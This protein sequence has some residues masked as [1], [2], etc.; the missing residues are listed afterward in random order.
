ML[1]EGSGVKLESRELSGRKAGRVESGLTFTYPQLPRARVY[2]GQH[3]RCR[4]LQSNHWRRCHHA[5]HLPI[6]VSTRRVPPDLQLQQRD[7]RCCAAAVLS[8]SRARIQSGKAMPR[9][10][11]TCENFAR[12]TC[13]QFRP[14]VVLE[15]P[16][17]GRTADAREEQICGRGSGRCGGQEGEV[18]GR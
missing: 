6:H 4:A 10:D 18:W 16:R 14:I 2:V 8:A 5:L 3:D 11:R 1:E 17:I 12:V 9:P 15:R 7:A 13:G